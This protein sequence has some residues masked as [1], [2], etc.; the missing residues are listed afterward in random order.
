MRRVRPTPWFD[1]ERRLVDLVERL[2]CDYEARVG[3]M[4]IIE[5][6]RRAREDLEA[7]H[8]TPPDDGLDLIESAARR[9]LDRVRLRTPA[10]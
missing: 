4:P 5:A 3:I 6:V 9:H 10:R 8:V 1:Y 2:A 7:R